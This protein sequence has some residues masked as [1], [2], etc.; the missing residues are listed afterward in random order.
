MKTILFI[1]TGNTCRSPMAVS[2]LKQMLKQNNLKANIISAGLDVKEN[3]PM[4]ENAK[5]ALKRLGVRKSKHMSKQLTKQML[6]KSDLVV[7]MTNQQKQYLP[8]MRKIISLADLIGQD[9][10]DPFMQN[11]EVY[12]ATAKQIQRALQKIVDYLKQGV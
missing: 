12:I 9:I 5:T 4:T 10:E 11:L 3:Q 7:T 8:K 1:C 2:I 6:D